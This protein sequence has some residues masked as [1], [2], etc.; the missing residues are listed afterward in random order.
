MFFVFLEY[1]PIVSRFIGFSGLFSN[2]VKVLSPDVDHHGPTGYSDKKKS[3]Q[4]KLFK[5]DNAQSPEPEAHAHRWEA[6][7][8]TTAP[9]LLP[10]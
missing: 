4:I 1:L 7:A 10:G 6:S 5:L 3:N 9:A 8:L 2:K